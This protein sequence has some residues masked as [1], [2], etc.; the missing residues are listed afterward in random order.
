ML[1][2]DEQKLA[3]ILE[4]EVEEVRPK[5]ALDRILR[6]AREREEDE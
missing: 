2:D 4:R 5:P 6:E 1:D 3:K